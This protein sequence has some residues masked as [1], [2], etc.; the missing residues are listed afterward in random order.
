MLVLKRSGKIEKLSRSKV[1][2][3]ISLL[4]K[5]EASTITDAILKGFPNKLESFKMKTYFADVAQSLG[6]SLIAGQI[7]MLKIHKEAPPTFTEAMLSLP[8]DKSFQD[9]IRKLQLDEFILKS[10]DFTYDLFALRTL[11]RSYLLRHNGKI[12]ETP[13]YMLMRVA[14]SLHD[15]K[16]KIL[17]CYNLMSSKKYTHATP[18]LYNAGMKNGQFA[19][20]FLGVMADDSIEGIFKTLSQCAQISK[21]AGGIGLSISNIRSKGSH[22][23]GAMGASNG[24]IPMLRV[25]NSCARYVDQGRRRKGA[26]AMYIEPWHADIFDFLELKKNHGDEERRTR[27]LF[28]ALWVPDLFMKRVRDDKQW[29]LFSPSDINLQDVHSEEFDKMYEEAEKKVPGRSV[30]ARDL[31]EK[32][33]RSQIETGVP[34]IMYKDKVNSCSNQKHLGTIRGSNLCAEIALYTSK[35]EVAVCTL[36]SV[37]LPKFVNRAFDFKM[38]GETVES[39]VEHL[40]RVIDV[41]SYPIPEAKSNLKH[42]PLGIGIQGY[43]DVFQKLDIPYDSEEAVHLGAAISECMYYHALKKSCQ[44]AKIHGPYESFKG[45]PASQGILQFDMHG[46]SPTRYDWDALKKDIQKHGLR[47]SQLIALMPTASTAQILGNSEGA[48]PRTSNLLARRVLSGEFVVENHILREKVTNWE[49]VKNHMKMN[50]GSIQNAPVSNQ[51]K[52]VFKTVWEI[53]QKWVINHNAARAPFVCQSQSM[54]LH[55]AKPTINKVNAMHF[56][57]WSKGLKTGCYYLRSKPAVNAVQLEC[58]SCSS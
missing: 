36:A 58:T 49:E 2:N 35:E 16:N 1:Q 21:K 33:I 31:W 52:S 42:R 40:D 37:A 39:V 56:Y 7:E 30:R 44:L 43:A 3:F 26:F 55:L 48:D 50:Y 32:V 20:C 10:N 29:T 4:D 12:L 45:S 22:I 54:N 23:T 57:A 28:L 34:Y 18:T 8:L 13:Q 17:D 24:I 27:D 5:N 47:N 19:S 11:T 9:K 14:A 38:L 15:D 51:I 53:S 46:V 6:H 25:F 41:T